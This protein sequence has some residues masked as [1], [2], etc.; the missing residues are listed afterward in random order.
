MTAERVS[1]PVIFVVDGKDDQLLIAEFTG[2]VQDTGLWVYPQRAYLTNHGGDGKTQKRLGTKFE[3]SSPDGK[4][5]DKVVFEDPNT[6]L[7][8]SGVEP[9]SYGIKGDVALDPSGLTDQGQAAA[10]RGETRLLAFRGGVLQDAILLQWFV[11]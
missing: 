4:P 11:E 6:P 1:V 9:T 10:K 8:A 5:Y 3:F 7:R 2:A